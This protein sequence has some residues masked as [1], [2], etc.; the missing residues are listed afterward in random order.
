MFLETKKRLL[1]KTF[2]SSY[3]QLQHQYRLMQQHQQQLKNQ[4]QVTTAPITRPNQAQISYTT[5]GQQFPVSNGT[6]RT[7]PLLG[8]SFSPPDTSEKL[9]QPTLTAP[10]PNMTRDINLPLSSTT[11]PNDLDVSEEDLQDLLS[12]KDLA[13]TLAE[14]LLKHFGSD[15]IDVKSEPVSQ[16]T[17]LSSGPF[18]PSNME[19]NKSQKQEINELSKRKAEDNLLSFKSEPFWEMEPLRPSERRPDSDFT[20]DMDARTILELCK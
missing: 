15:D 13:T 1:M 19:S 2:Q 17:T 7:S 9:L 5:P 3:Q 20:I 10:V 8:K 12:Q 18:S 14:N 16:E 6:N 4:R 11:N